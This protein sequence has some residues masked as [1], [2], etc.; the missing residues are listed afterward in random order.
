[1]KIEKENLEET[2][3]VKLTV[4]VDPEQIEAAKRVAARKIAQK[5]NVPG[6]RKGKA[7]YEIVLRTFGDGAV[8][9]EALDDLGQKAYEQALKNR[10]RS[11]CAGS[12]NRLQERPHHVYLQ[13][14]ASPRN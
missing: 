5:H 2:C 8:L 13:R 4:E 6:F 12:V 1:M 3:E 7:P 9:E 14:A 11:C 10:D